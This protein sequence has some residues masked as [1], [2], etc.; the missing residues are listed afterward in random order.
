MTAGEEPK[1]PA[2]KGPLRLAERAHQEATG[3][4][5]PLQAVEMALEG[6]EPAQEVGEPGPKAAEPA[7]EAVELP[8][9][10]AEPALEAGELPPEAAEPG[11][12]AV[13]LGVEA[14]DPAQEVGELPPEAVAKM[15]A[16][17]MERHRPETVARMPQGAVA[18][19]KRPEE[20]SPMRSW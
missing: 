1:D 4:K 5:Q 16:E 11:P 7:Q 6:A 17:V 15:R 9:E 14:G 12:E 20:A 3:E 8:P 2:G 19:P 10:A 18:P 13:E